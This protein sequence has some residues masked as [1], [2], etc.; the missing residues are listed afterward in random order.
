MVRVNMGIGTALPDWLMGTS[1]LDCGF[2][3]H[4]FNGY[5]QT[6]VRNDLRRS[7]VPTARASAQAR[8]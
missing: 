6:H 3:G 4:L 5:D 7:F 8:S 1:D 2:W